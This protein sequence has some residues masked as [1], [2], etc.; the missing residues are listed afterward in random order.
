MRL[1]YKISEKPIADLDGLESSLWCGG[2]SGGDAIVEAAN[3]AADRARGLSST[4]QRIANVLE[5]VGFR[6]SDYDEK[7]APRL[8]AIVMSEDLRTFLQV[9]ETD[10]WYV[11]RDLGELQTRL[12]WL[13]ERLA[14]A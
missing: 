3:Q 14:N 10:I 5:R 11:D 13:R 9:V 6:G 7:R 4:Y 8:D 2:I 12:N 1:T